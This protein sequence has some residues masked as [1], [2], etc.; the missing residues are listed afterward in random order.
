MCGALSGCRRTPVAWG[1]AAQL[2][3]ASVAVAGAQWRLAID[4]RGVPSAEAA[5][6]PLIAAPSGMC[7]NSL[8]AARV[9]G[10][11][12]FAAWWTARADSSVSL[13]VSRTTND[14]AA[15]SAPVAADARD[16]GRRGC[17]RPAP[18][19]AADSATGYVHLAYFLEPAEG[20]GV[21]LVHSMEHGAMWHSPVALAFGADPA[22]ASVAAFG[23]TVAAAF[24]SPNGREGSISVALSNSDGHL[25]DHTLPW[26]SGRSVPVEGPR[27]ALRGRWIAVAWVTQRGGLVF[28]RTGVRQ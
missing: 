12:W 18:A 26:V 20:A 24:E 25:I 16:A 4:G 11:E 8:V 7:P 27:I 14:S 21:W 28:V 17:E 3:S 6:V 5:K 19:M 9:S 1:E 2:T 22:A 23:D 13:M 10:G 15:W